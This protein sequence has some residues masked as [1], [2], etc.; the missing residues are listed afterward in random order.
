MTVMVLILMM[1]G[2][3]AAGTTDGRENIVCPAVNPLIRRLRLYLWE[4][5]KS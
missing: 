2:R 4:K 3:A 1:T 5:K